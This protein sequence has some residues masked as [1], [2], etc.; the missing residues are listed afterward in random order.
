MAIKRSR[1]VQKEMS[2]KVK[3]NGPRFVRKRGVSSRCRNL[4]ARPRQQKGFKVT[5]EQCRLLVVD[6]VSPKKG[7]VSLPRLCGSGALLRLCLAKAQPLFLPL[8]HE[9]EWGG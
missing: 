2:C 3:T 8:P 7:K 4:S 1:D 5:K 6:Y 9:H